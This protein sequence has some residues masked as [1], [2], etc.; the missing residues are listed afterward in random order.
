M[1]NIQRLKTIQKYVFSFTEEKRKSFEKIPQNLEDLQSFLK[2]T[3]VDANGDVQAIAK[4]V[5]NAFS[6]YDGVPVKVK[7]RNNKLSKK[8]EKEN[9]YRKENGKE[10]LQFVEEKAYD[11]SGHLINPPGINRNIYCI[12]GHKV[13][14]A[15]IVKDG[16]E[17]TEHIGNYTKQPNDPIPIGVINRLD[18]QKGQP[19]YIPEH[20]RP[21]VNP[22]KKR[23]HK[24]Y[25][26]NSD[27]MR[28]AVLGII[29]IGKDWILVDLRGHPRSPT[30][31]R[32]PTFCSA[33]A[34]SSPSPF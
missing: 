4:I 27:K 16:K 2:G 21:F 25:E 22:N 26:N 34:T 3:N 33:S 14:A 13:R 5:K 1:A 19:G 6:T 23:I 29:R 15:D 24:R 32:P 17:I 20:Q 8:I 11:E 7:N 30:S 9:K 31:V 18:I 12:Q 28:D 10:L